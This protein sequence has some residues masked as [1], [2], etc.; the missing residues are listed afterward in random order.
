METPAPPETDPA[1][2][3]TVPSGF[4]EWDSQRLAGYKTHVLAAIRATQL[5]REPFYHLFI[6]SIL[7]SELYDAVEHHM[8]AHKHPDLMQPRRQDNPEFVNRRFSLHQSDDLPIQY[9]RALFSD[10][11]VK[12]SFF[13]RFYLDPPSEL[14]DRVAI[15]NEFEYTFTLGERFQTVHLD[16]PPK[17]MSFVFYL[18]QTAVSDEDELRNAT[19]LY[20]RDLEPHRVA[21]YRRNTVCVF[22]PHFAS[23]HGFDSTIP[24]DALVMFYVDPEELTSWRAIPPERRDYPPYDGITAAIKA[25]LERYPLHEYGEKG[26]SLDREAERCRVNAPQGRVVQNAVSPGAD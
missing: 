7:P 14:L 10:V 19:I 24:R 13:E 21:R 18:P 15:H 8:I 23:Y 20:D 2:A 16:I 25:K 6:E 22:V 11:D 9:V 5:G 1:P 12:R 26:L 4:E 17:Y 3:Y